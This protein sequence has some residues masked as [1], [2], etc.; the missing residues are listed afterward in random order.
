VQ[1]ADPAVAAQFLQ[2]TLGNVIHET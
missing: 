1:V 2:Y